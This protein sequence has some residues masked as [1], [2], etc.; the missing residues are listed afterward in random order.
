VAVVCASVLVV[1]VAA[2]VVVAGPSDEIPCG[3]GSTLDRLAQDVMTPLGGGH[4]DGGDATLCV[5]PSPT[6]WFIGTLV[7]LVGLGTI[8]LVASRRRT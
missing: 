4:I 3:T 6:A 1:L 8:L 5:V 7:F 2:G